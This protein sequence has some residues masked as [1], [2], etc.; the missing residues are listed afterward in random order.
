MED[1]K[2]LGDL[3]EDLACAMLY[4]QGY[5][6]LEKKYRCRVGEIDIIAEKDRETVFAEVKT[7]TTLRFGA[8]A[9]AVDEK[10]KRR[11]RKA[12]EYYRMMNGISYKAASFMVIEVLVRQTANAF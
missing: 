12:A 7:R 10:K 1:K 8:P 4:A 9:E 6:I 3:G 2:L 5:D 11:M